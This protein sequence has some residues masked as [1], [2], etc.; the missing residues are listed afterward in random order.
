MFKVRG[1][2]EAQYF[3]LALAPHMITAL[4]IEEMLSEGKVRIAQSATKVALY[5]R[6]CHM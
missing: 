1:F 5:F 3:L 4:D 2:S 6:Y